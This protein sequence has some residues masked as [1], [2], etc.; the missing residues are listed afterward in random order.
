[1]ARIN[2]SVPLELSNRMNAVGN[3]I[4]WSAVAREA[5]E[6]ALKSAERD[7]LIVTEKREG[8]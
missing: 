6:R 7:W 3:R 8:A 1:M 2:I 4:N 5:F